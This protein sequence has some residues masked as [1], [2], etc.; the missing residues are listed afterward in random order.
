MNANNSINCK[1]IHLRHKLLGCALTSFGC[2]VYWM[3]N[4]NDSVRLLDLFAV[5][6]G[7]YEAPDALIVDATYVIVMLMF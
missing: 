2:Y 5:I 1:F 3:Y 4:G 7:N 6:N